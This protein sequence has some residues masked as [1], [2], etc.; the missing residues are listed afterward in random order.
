MSS[1][2]QLSNG[3]KSVAS[4]VQQLKTGFGPLQDG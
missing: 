4:G 2:E 3:T 1:I